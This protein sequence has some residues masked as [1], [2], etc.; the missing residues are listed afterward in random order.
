M[1]FFIDTTYKSYL[2]EFQPISEMIVDVRERSSQAEYESLLNYVWN[3]HK[4]DYDALIA[5]EAPDFEIKAERYAKDEIRQLNLIS[6][7][8]S[9]IKFTVDLSNTMRLYAICGI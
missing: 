3:R 7:E 8:A 4:D 2:S 6:M 1:P 5:I 9:G